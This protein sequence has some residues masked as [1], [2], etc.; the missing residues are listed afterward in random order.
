TWASWHRQ[1]GTS[2][3]ELKD[4]GRWKSRVMVD[5]YAKFAT[6]NPAVAASRIERGRGGN[7]VQFPRVFDTFRKAKGQPVG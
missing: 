6:E 1:A 2:T 3:D 7:V 5:R 4:L